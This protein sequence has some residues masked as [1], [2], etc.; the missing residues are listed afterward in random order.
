MASAPPLLIGWNPDSHQ[1]SISKGL[2][3]TVQEHPGRNGFGANAGP[4][5]VIRRD[6]LYRKS[7]LSISFLQE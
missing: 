7:P 3:F 4:E 1:E 6:C 2:L 5:P